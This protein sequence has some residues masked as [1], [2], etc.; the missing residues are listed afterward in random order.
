MSSSEVSRTRVEWLDSL[1]GILIVLVVVG[2]FILPVHKVGEPISITYDTI[3]M[4]HMPLF[5]FVSGLFGKHV[6]DGS[7]HLRINKILTYCLIGILYGF[8]LRLMEGSSLSLTSLLSFS[9]APWYVICLASWMILVPFFDRLKPAYGITIAVVISLISTVQHEQ[10]DFLALSRTAHFLPYYFGG[11]YLSTSD[12]SK[13]RDSKVRVFA[14]VFAVFATG[15]FLCIRESISDYFFLVY[16]NTSGNLPILN[17]VIGYI[18]LNLLGI[19]LS[20][21]CIAAAPKRN[22]LLKFLGERTLQIYILHRFV[23]G[24]LQIGGFYDLMLGSIDSACLT[25]CILLLLSFA[26]CFVSTV[27]SLTWL[28]KKLLSLSWKPIIRGN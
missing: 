16:G 18:I 14:I 2:H 22:R 15:I 10:T 6:I 20:I 12:L 23:R 21:G 28:S 25:L 13:I 1:K 26:T 4:F 27:P 19:A 17:A 5:V 8:F 3:Y 11:Y 9:S 24:A 7:G